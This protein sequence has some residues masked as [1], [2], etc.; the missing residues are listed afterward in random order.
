MANKAVLLVLMQP[1]NALED[2]FNAWYDAEH[3]PERAAVPGFESALRFVA[4]AGQ[5]RYLAIY[6]LARLDVLDSA[7][8]LKVA[9][10]NSSP[11]TKRVTGRTRI[12][13]SAGE[14]IY[15]GSAVTRRCARILLLRFRALTAAAQSDII[16]GMRANFEERSETSQI[17]VFAYSTEAGTDYLGVVEAMGPTDDRLDLAAFGQSAKALDLVNTYAPY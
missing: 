12:Y 14:Q 15:P 1:P 17:R 2:E 9:F 11:W 10:E 13:R 16:G 8:Y 7:D 4:L 6:D 5:P 3:I